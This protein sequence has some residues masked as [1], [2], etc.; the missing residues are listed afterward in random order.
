MYTEAGKQLA[1]RLWNETQQELRGKG[2][3]DILRSLDHKKS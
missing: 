3:E 1:G 2:V